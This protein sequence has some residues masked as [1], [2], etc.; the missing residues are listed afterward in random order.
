M[1]DS[2]MSTQ[3]VE[4]LPRLAPVARVGYLGVITLAVPLKLVTQTL[5]LLYRYLVRLID[6]D[7]K[8]IDGVTTLN[9]CTIDRIV[10]MGGDK[11]RIRVPV[12][13]PFKLIAG[14]DRGVGVEMIRYR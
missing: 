3:G 13:I 9:G 5:P 4:E 7:M 6:E 12:E 2:S 1:T 14:T 11:G 8:V 10:Q